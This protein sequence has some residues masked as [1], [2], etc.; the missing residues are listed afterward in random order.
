MKLKIELDKK[1][2]KSDFIHNGRIISRFFKKLSS[3]IFKQSYKYY[4][5]SKSIIGNSELPILLAERNLYSTVA[6]AIDNITHVH[7]T[8]WSFSAS[9]HKIDSSRRV[10]FWCLS[11]DGKMGKP[12]NYFIELKKGWYCLNERSHEDFNKSVKESID[13]LI[14]QTKSLKSISPKWENV[15]DVFL[16]IVI[17]HGYYRDGVESYEAKQVRDNL[18]KQI[19]NRSNAQMIISTWTLPDNMDIQWEKN[20]CRFISIAGVVITRKR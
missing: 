17:I 8:E 7:L 19:D 1:Y 13:S 11:K 2:Y 5:S 15:E 18:Y 4:R 3:N 10:D 20:K 6:V 16:G 12:I 9:D 14:Q